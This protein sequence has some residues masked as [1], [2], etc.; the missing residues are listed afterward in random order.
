MSLTEGE[1]EC[2]RAGNADRPPSSWNTAQVGRCHRTC[3]F[4][5]TLTAQDPVPTRLVWTHRSPTCQT[6]I[7]PRPSWSH[8]GSAQWLFPADQSND[9][10]ARQPVFR[11]FPSLGLPGATSEPHPSQP[12]GPPPIR[13]KPTCPNP[14]DARCSHGQSPPYRENS[15]ASFPMKCLFAQR[16]LLPIQ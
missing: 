13:E 7:L 2:P 5:K 10:P 16:G 12:W 11:L 6:Q 15:Q 9:T 1:R 14:R 4:W 3:T 8:Q